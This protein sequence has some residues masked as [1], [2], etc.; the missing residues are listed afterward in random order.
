MSKGFCGLHSL[1]TKKS[2][3]TKMKARQHVHLQACKAHDHD[4][5]WTYM[6]WSDCLKTKGNVKIKLRDLCETCVRL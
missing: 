1:S 6:Q 4:H 3:M 5:Q 2:T